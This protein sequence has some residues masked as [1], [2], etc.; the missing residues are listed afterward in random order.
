MMK[1]TIT[2]ATLYLILKLVITRTKL[3]KNDSYRYEHTL[4]VGQIE[5]PYLG[6]DGVLP[7]MR[8]YISSN[9]WHALK[10]NEVALS[11]IIA[12]HTTL[13]ASHLTHNF[14]VIK[15]APNYINNNRKLVSS[16]LFL[17]MVVNAHDVETNPGPYKP[18]FPCQ[19]CDKAVK[20][21]QRGVRCDTCL[22]WCHIDCMGMGTRTYENLDGSR[23]IWF[24]ST[25]NGSNYSA[26]HLFSNSN[27]EV[28]NSFNS[29]SIN[30]NDEVQMG[31]PKATSS[32]ID[33][34]AKTNL[35]KNSHKGNSKNSL[36][37]AVINFQS[38]SAKREAL[39][40]FIETHNPDVIIGTESWLD[41]TVNNNEI[42]PPNFTAVRKD[43]NTNT[44]HGGVLVATRNDIISVHQTE[45]DTECEIVWVELQ[46]MGCKKLVIGAF[47]RPPNKTDS[48]YLDQ[49]K[50]SLNR[51]NITQDTMIC[52]G[53]D[54]NLG[55]INWLNNSVVPGA[56]FKAQSETLI[57]ISEQFDLEQ[58]VLE[59]TREK[60]ILDLFFTSNPTLVKNVIVSPGISDHDGIPLIELNTKPLITKSKPRK[61]YIFKKANMEGLQ[62][63]MENLNSNILKRD[64]TSSQQDWCE[65]RDGIFKSMDENIPSKMTSKRNN[66][67]WITTGIRRKLRKKQ[68]IYNRAKK[69]GTEDDLMKFKTI[70]KEIQKESKL[71][72]WRWVRSSCISSTKQFY[73][74]IKKLRKDSVGIPALKHQGKLISDN[75]GKAEILNSHFESVF[76]NEE[77]MKDFTAQRATPPMQDFHIHTGGVAKLL[78]KLEENKAPGP[79]GLTPYIL[80][81]FADTLAP[82][83]THIFNKSLTTGALPL[84][85]LTANIT[86]IYKKGDR[87]A[88]ANYRPVSLTPI[89][90][91]VFEHIVHSNIMKHLTKHNILTDKQ[92]GFRKHHSCETQ[93]IQTV[94]DIAGSLDNRTPL[95]MIIM[96][97]SKAF[98][99]V[100][101]N[102]LLYKLHNYGITGNIH[103][104]ISNFLTQRRQRVV[105]NGDHSKWVHVRSGVPQ[106]TV[107]GPLLF[108]IYL[109]DLP[110]NITSEMR[111]FADDCVIYRLIKC[112]QD[113][114]NLQHDLNQ[115][116]LWQQKWQMHFNVSKCFVIKFTH[117]KKP[118]THTYQL[119]NTI[120]S[121]TKS[122]TYLGIH[123][124]NDL[125]WNDHVNHTTTKAKRVLG[126]LRRNLHPCPTD[127][128]STAYKT[129]VR[130]QL[131]YASTVWNPHTKENIDKIESIQRRSAR[132][133]C[134][135]YDYTSSVT[136]MLSRLEWDPLQT[137]REAASLTMLQ[138]IH[139]SQVAIP[140][141][142]FL[143]PV[144]RPSRHHNSK[145]YQRYQ[146]KKDCFKHS[147]FPSTISSWN[148]LPEHLVH[149]SETPA[150]KEA[151]STHLRENRRI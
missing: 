82:A 140:A 120:L 15:H 71:S 7:Y 101:H 123:L 61:Q 99:T 26:G 80:K 33:I 58:L 89:C 107:L 118:T 8:S 93:L 1:F 98:D 119:G 105:V 143:R 48:K 63:D 32:P 17:L 51:I 148:T 128:K 68:R 43:R 133:A 2:I 131:E 16:F 67:P 92:H 21:G 20:W 4:K 116:S 146:A 110:N 117:A 9:T 39:H 127:L 44:G 104:W 3:A 144:N 126:M 22:E 38:I 108:L 137:R 102:R 70:R 53:G 18:K 62:K 10:F 5:L 142:K 77:D 25:C 54:F 113:I 114:I 115:L 42:F 64:V 40:I 60:K 34:Q 76:T 91:K 125:K 129:L 12:K 96:D 57:E 65:F 90:C 145:A 124:S 81:M 111:L 88:A 72:Y 97:F 85:W 36:K 86:P 78:H 13:H 150:F 27:I 147:F 130:P 50:L 121:E 14:A 75:T 59:P 83:L 94:H 6:Q 47:Y 103:T 49:L 11:M 141:Q 28:S 56:R 151:V 52:L 106:G 46:L 149:I 112:A 35:K 74:F 84:D 30:S 122:H 138:K 55:D 66:T 136:S 139:T 45:L 95:D 109:N 73:G 19:V 132:F 79:D 31:L 41:D 29:L 100:P 134:R 37:I 23:V 69:S 24:C 135:D 87:T